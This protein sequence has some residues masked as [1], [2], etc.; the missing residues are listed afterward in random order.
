MESEKTFREMSEHDRR[1]YITHII[2][3]ILYDDT[4]FKQ[5]SNLLED[6]SMIDVLKEG[7]SIVNIG[8]YGDQ[9][10]A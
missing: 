1:V 3:H 8:A 5:I 6:W 4:K 2:Q 10:D 7:V 9:L